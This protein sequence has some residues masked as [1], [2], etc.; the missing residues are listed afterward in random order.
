MLRPGVG[1]VEQCA[2]VARDRDDNDQRQHA[3]KLSGIDCQM[4]AAR[5][6]L[7]AVRLYVGSMLRII[8]ESAQPEYRLRT[9][10]VACILHGVI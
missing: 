4:Q 9:Y 6:C 7:S 5:T 8:S 10:A 2:T 1:H 3:H